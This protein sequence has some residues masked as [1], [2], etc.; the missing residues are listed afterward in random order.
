MPQSIAIIA[1]TIQTI[2]QPII[3]LDPTGRILLANS[4]ARESAGL[5][6]KQKLFDQVVDAERASGFFEM[7]RSTTMPV[8]TRLQLKSG[9]QGVAFGHRLAIPETKLDGAVMIR[10]DESM[11]LSAKFAALNHDIYSLT[12]KV[13]H[14][15][16]EN[17]QLESLAITDPLTKVYNRRGFDR[18]LEKEFSRATRY[19]HV[20][21]ITLI[22][23]D[24]FKVFNDTHGHQLGDE[25]LVHFAERCQEHLRQTDVFCRVGG[26]EFALILPETGLPQA[27]IVVNR[28]LELINATPMHANGQRYAYTASAGLAVLRD[29]D[30]PENLYLRADQN[31]YAAKKQGRACLIHDL[32]GQLAETFQDDGRRREVPT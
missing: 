32:A 15:G 26:E 27:T 6:E 31:L 1:A 12:S 8:P 23:L 7:C 2:P 22:D 25:V 24:H 21:C 20:F 17:S 28:M 18:E 14:F 5:S 16:R 10:F 13:R 30:T 29:G 11:N 9:F 19:G 4:S 3:I